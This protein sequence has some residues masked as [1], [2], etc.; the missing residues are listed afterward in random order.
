MTARQQVLYGGLGGGIGF[1]F[2]VV[3]FVGNVEPHMVQP[4]QLIQLGFE[5]RQK[6]PQKPGIFSPHRR[7][8]PAKP[9]F[10]SRGGVHPD[11]GGK[12]GAPLGKQVGHLDLGDPM[13]AAD[14]RP[15]AQ[16]GK[17]KP[18]SFAVPVRLHQLHR[19]AL[20]SLGGVQGRGEHRG[21]EHIDAVG[22]GTADKLVQNGPMFLAEHRDSVVIGQTIRVE[23]LGLIQGL[24]RQRL[25]QHLYGQDKAGQRFPLCGEGLQTK[26]CVA[27][28]Q[29]GC[30]HRHPQAAPLGRHGPYG[31]MGIQRNQQIRQQTGLGG[32]IVFVPGAVAG[33]VAGHQIHPAQLGRSSRRA[34]APDPELGGCLAEIIVGA[35]IRQL[36]G[37]FLVLQQHRSVL[38]QRRG[39]AGRQ[40]LFQTVGQ[41]KGIT[42]HNFLLTGRNRI[43][44]ALYHPSRRTRGRNLPPWESSALCG[45]PSIIPPGGSP[46]R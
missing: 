36:K 10:R 12:L 27:G 5:G 28:L 13:P 24:G 18:V 14:I 30:V 40:H 7:R 37:P 31:L 23:P 4:H 25:G 39:P 29:P 42:S 3:G 2:V 11:L 32:Q 9:F 17:I 6:L 20:P 44:A 1:L 16:P 33:I 21:Q 43:W 46:G 38:L 8:M 41:L 22:G 34:A 26:L 19:G 35:G 15:A 45:Y